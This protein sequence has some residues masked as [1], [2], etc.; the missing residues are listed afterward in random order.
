MPEESFDPYRPPSVDSPE[1][2]ASGKVPPEVER[3]RA[4]LRLLGKVWIAIGSSLSL[5]TLFPLWLIPKNYLPSEKLLLAAVAGFGALCTAAGVGLSRL[6][7]WV[8]PLATLCAIGVCVVIPVLGLGL[9]AYLLFL[10]YTYPGPAALGLEQAID[11]SREPVTERSK[12]APGVVPLLLIL[13]FALLTLIAVAVGL[14]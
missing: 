12:T 8:R 1:R 14:G 9:G 3:R 11:T 5:L 4:A 6:S 10:L 2:V 13:G 7:S